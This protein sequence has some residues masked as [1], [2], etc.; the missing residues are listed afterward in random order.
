MSKRDTELTVIESCLKQLTT[1]P[2]A[3]QKRVV[4]YLVQRVEEEK[5]QPRDEQPPAGAAT[6]A[7]TEPGGGST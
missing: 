1:L 3:S 7:V 6:V 5:L 4:E 2:V